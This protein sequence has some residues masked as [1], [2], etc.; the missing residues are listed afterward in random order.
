[1]S[2][3]FEKTINGQKYIFQ[4]INTEG[5]IYYNVSFEHE[6]SIEAFQLKKDASGKWKIQGRSLPDFVNNIE[7]DLSNAIEENIND[8]LG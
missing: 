5:E 7:T 3:S 6:T 4:L 8:P 1:M 2:D